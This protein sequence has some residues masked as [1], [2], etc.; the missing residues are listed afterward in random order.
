MRLREKCF[1]KEVK[2]SFSQKKHRNCEKGEKGV[3]KKVSGTFYYL[4]Y[5]KHSVCCVFCITL[6][7]ITNISFITSSLSVFLSFFVIASVLKERVAISYYHLIVVIS[8]TTTSFRFASVL[9]VTNFL[10]NVIAKR[11]SAVAISG[12]ASIFSLFFVIASVLEKRVA[13]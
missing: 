11:F 12:I 3:R 7:V 5:K 6:F 1:K 8:E 9:A 10:S 4:L 13:I 2:L